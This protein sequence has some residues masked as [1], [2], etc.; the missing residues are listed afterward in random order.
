[1]GGPGPEQA[2]FA[3]RSCPRF[4]RRSDRYAGV[5]KRPVARR[6]AH[7]SKPAFARGDRRSDAARAAADRKRTV[8]PDLRPVGT[9]FASH[10]ISFLRLCFFEKDDRKG[11][12]T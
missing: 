8:G 10:S 6:I 12:Q 1:M 4:G 9:P 3:G 11:R 7:W 5:T 2:N